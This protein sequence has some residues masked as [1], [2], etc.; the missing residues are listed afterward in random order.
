MILKYSIGIDIGSTSFR[1]CIVTIDEKQQVKTKASR[2]FENNNNGFDAFK[3]WFEKYYKQTH[4]PICFC[5][6]ATGVY[7]EQLAHFLHDQ[8]HCV[9]IILAN[10]A[11]KYLESLALKTKNDKIDAKGLAQM[12]AERSLRT[13]N[14]P[15]EFY[16]TLRS[17]T[18]YYQHLQE[19]KTV[20]N[21][22]LHAMSVAKHKTPVVIKETKKLIKN[23]DNKINQA[24]IQ[25]CQYLKKDE[26][27][28]RKVKQICAIK[29]VAELTVAVIIAETYGFELI[30]NAKQLSSY[31]GYDVVE[32]QSGK[33]QGK[34]KISKKGNS[35]IRRAL[36]LPAFIA[37]IHEPV[38]NNFFNRT[39][40]K[41]KIK[42][43]SYV[44]IQ[45]KLLTT[46]F[47][48]WKKDEAFDNQFYKKMEEKFEIHEQ[49]IVAPENHGL[50]LVQKA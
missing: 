49:K 21:N 37:K 18:R 26:D 34:T 22:R 10:S 45:R 1:S 11:K 46:I 24:R 44:A 29:G 20:E 15:V 47:A 40:D 27:V 14:P 2:K 16:A 9:S 35:R 5:M 13:W 7:Y 42:M 31:A 3:K 17:L 4:I 32:N 48:L 25:I 39:F 41:H 28:A 6:E 38:F 43:K 30:Q 36:Y 19:L 8:G 33:R 23:L 50:L 12:G